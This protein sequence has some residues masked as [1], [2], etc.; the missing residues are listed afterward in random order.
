MDQG[1]ANGTF[2]DSQRVAEAILR[3]GQELRFGAVSFKVEMEDDD[4]SSHGGGDAFA[5][6]P[7]SW[8]APR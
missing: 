4:I 8:P 2:L 1:S 3:T 7:R 5:R 6:R